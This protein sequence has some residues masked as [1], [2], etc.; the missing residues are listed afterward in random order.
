LTSV[1]YYTVF[2]ELTEKSGKQ[3]VSNCS[4]FWKT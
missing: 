2:L 3:A 1:W 4:W